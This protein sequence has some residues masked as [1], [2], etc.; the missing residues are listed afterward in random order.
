MCLFITSKPGTAISD[1]YKKDRCS[2]EETL[3][4]PW[5]KS[6]RVLP[7][8]LLLIN[9]HLVFLVHLFSLWLTVSQLFRVCCRKLLSENEVARELVYL[10]CC[11]GALTANFPFEIVRE[12][13]VSR[14]R[15]SSALE[16]SC[17][18]LSLKCVCSLFQI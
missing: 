18:F 15:W 2:N 5:V 8:W 13:I 16:P 12:G 1:V 3:I 17:F 11:A 9:Q 6:V 10:L 14:Q 4:S 7:C